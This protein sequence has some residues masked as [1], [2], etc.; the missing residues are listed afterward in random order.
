MMAAMG[1]EF[2]EQVISTVAAGRAEW[3]LH[4]KF[5]LA[6]ES[7]AGAT[8]LETYLQRALV[9]SPALVDGRHAYTL[10]D[11]RTDHRESKTFATLQRASSRTAAR[12]TMSLFDYLMMHLG[13]EASR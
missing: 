10:A 12:A 1:N 6:D 8:S 4:G 2:D 5:F 7:V 13:S 3:T 9:A 11:V